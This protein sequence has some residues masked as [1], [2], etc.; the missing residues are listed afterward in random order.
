MTANT[1]VYIDNLNFSG[2]L[3]ALPVVQFPAACWSG[4]WVGTYTNVT[5]SG[6][7]TNAGNMTLTLSVTNGVVSGTVLQSG[8]MATDG[9]CGFVC[10]G[11]LSGPISGIFLIIALLSADRCI[12]NVTIIHTVRDG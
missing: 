12:R 6:C 5:Y 11:T 8:N 9:H 3:V 1:T 7:F 10:S 4:T 2:S